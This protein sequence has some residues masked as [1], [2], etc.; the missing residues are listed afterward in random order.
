MMGTA[1]DSR[2]CRR[3]PS[4]LLLPGALMNR[5]LLGTPVL[6]ALVSCASAPSQAPEDTQIG[7][8]HV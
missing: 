5:L 1:T 2:V 3:L 4:R 7:R 8:A 6:L